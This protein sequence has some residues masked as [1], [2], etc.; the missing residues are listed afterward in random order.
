MKPLLLKPL[1]DAL[2]TVRNHIDRH[3]PC[4]PGER[5]QNQETFN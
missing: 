1:T 4:A 5:K 2:E 3:G